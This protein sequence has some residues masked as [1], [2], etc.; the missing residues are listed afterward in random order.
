MKTRSQL[1]CGLRT[2]WARPHP[3][4][5]PQE[6]EKRSTVI[7]GRSRIPSAA[8][9]NALSK[10]AAKARAAFKHYENAH[11]SS[12]SPGERVRVRASVPSN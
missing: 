5:L 6:R 7:G 3:D 2:F 9:F 12:L 8:N 1:Q 11:G 10:D 4:P